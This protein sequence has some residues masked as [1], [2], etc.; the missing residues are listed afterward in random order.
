MSGTWI[1]PSACLVLAYG[2]SRVFWTVWE[3]AVVMSVV[4]VGVGDCQN[5][6][7]VG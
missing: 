3:F 2:M 7:I 6:S 5:Y 4:G 1:L